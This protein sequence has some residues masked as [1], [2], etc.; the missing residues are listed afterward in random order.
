MYDTA[1]P[2]TVA[3]LRLYNA[4]DGDHLYT[5]SDAERVSAIANLGPAVPIPT[6]I[7]AMQSVY[8]AAGIAVR[9]VS[10]TTLSAPGLLDINV[11]ACNGTPTPQQEQLFAHRAGMSDTDVAIYIVRSTV[12]PFNGCATHPSGRPGAVVA[13]MSTQWTMGHEIGHVLDLVHVNNNDRLMTGNGTANITN[14]PPDLIASEIKAMDDSPLTL[15][16]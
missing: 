1:Q 11:G 6:S 13:A 3:L 5:T 4:E 2:G 14:P 16:V 9:L 10:T 8:D 15:D 7:S 12:P